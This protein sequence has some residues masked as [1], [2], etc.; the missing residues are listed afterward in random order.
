MKTFAT[1]SLSLLAAPLAVLAMAIPARAN[2]MVTEGA[3]G[4]QVPLTFHAQ[5]TWYCASG[6]GECKAPAPVQRDGTALDLAWQQASVSTN[7][8]SGVTGVTAF[9]ICDCN[10]S[11]GT[12]SYLITPAAGLNNYGPDTYTVPV[13]IVDPPPGPQ[14]MPDVTDEEIAAWDEPDP[15]WPQGVDCVAWC[16][17]P[18]IPETVPDILASDVPIAT[19]VIAD[20]PVAADVPVVQPDTGSSKGCAAGGLAS[21]VTGLPFAAAFALLALARIRRRPAA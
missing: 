14:T 20:V 15:P 6:F 4:L 7:T 10:L 1:G 17:N 21:P 19:D 16:A 9:Q 5:V 11:V 8:G 18:P 3:H 12:Y 2:P 13:A